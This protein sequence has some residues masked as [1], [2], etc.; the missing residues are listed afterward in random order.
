MF[1]RVQIASQETITPNSVNSPQN[2]K[3][4]S[5]HLQSW[6]ATW[7]Y[8]GRRSP[9]IHY[10]CRY[11]S[12]NMYIRVRECNV[13]AMSFPIPYNGREFLLLLPHLIDQH[14]QR[15]NHTWTGFPAPDEA[16]EFAP[17][18]YTIVIWYFGCIDVNKSLMNSF[19]M[20]TSTILTNEGWTL[21]GMGESEFLSG[22]TQ[23]A[24]RRTL[25]CNHIM[26][27]DILYCFL[28]V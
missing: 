10:Y 21:T 16:S 17:D 2:K 24:F 9:T 25:V 6:D 15:L 8:A 23:T 22:S 7:L 13:L 27:F 12:Y 3:K 18:K 20:L 14:F 11:R 1:Q 26:N 28:I 5:L 19:L 4:Q